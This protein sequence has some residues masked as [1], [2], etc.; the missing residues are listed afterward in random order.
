M[1]RTPTERALALALLL[2]LPAAQALTLD[3]KPLA[4]VQV[5]HDSNIFRSPDN[6]APG[7]GSAISDTIITTGVGGRLT[8]RESLQT[9]EL[10]GDFDHLKY[11]DQNQLDHDRR[12]LSAEARLNAGSTLHLTL[13]G[14]EERRLE[15]FAYRD[16]SQK[17]FVTASNASALLAYDLT[18]RWTVE[19]QA[20]RF[21]SRASLASSTDFNLVEHGANLGVRY[22]RNGYSSLGLSLRQVEGEYPARVVIAGDGR[23]K[24]YTQ[25]SLLAKAGYTPSGISDLSAQLGYTQRLHSD[26]SVSD[27]RGFTGRLGYTRQVSGRTRL[28]GEAYRDLFYVEEVGAN[29]AENLGLLLAADYRYSAK[30][31]FAAAVESIQSDYRGASGFQ[32]ASGQQRSDQLLSLR[33]GADYRPFYRFSVLPEYRWERRESNLANSGYSYSSFALD[34]TYAYGAELR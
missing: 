14:S 21:S 5:S 27:F 24:S 28:R 1:T 32:A 13:N 16:D 2:A 15:N 17:S 8:L 18:P 9:L 26:A 11:L 30:L 22:A 20:D 25:S 33:V 7:A 10:R 12:R 23:E 3:L 4:R 19:A 29:F 31:A 34:L 6:P